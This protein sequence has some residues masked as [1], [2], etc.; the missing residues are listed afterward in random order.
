[1]GVASLGYG[2]NFWVGF[3]VYPFLT[4]TVLIFLNGFVK[5]VV[6]TNL[7]ESSSVWPDPRG[8]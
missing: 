4:L 2:V 7:P 1:M 6:G 3:C 5:L 8:I